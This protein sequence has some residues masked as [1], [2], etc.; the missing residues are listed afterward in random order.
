MA[1]A[2]AVVVFDAFAVCVEAY[3]GSEDEC[4]VVDG[5]SHQ[6]IDLM[7][8]SSQG[9]RFFAAALSWRASAT[10]MVAHSF[11]AVMVFQ[12]VPHSS[13]TCVS[14]SIISCT[15]IRQA[16]RLRYGELRLPLPAR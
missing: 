11:A 2:L 1:D 7:M 5:V 15:A 13:Q 4:R 12:P 8:L 9:L 6:L 10:S 16:L 3:G 14:S